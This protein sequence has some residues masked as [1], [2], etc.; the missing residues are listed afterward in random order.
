MAA[1]RWQFSAGYTLLWFKGGTYPPLATTGNVNDTFPGAIGQPGTVILDNGNRSPGASSAFRTTFTYWL[2][3]PEVFCFDANFF[4]MEQRSVLRNFASDANGLPLLARP[5]FNPIS[6]SEDADP[7]AVPFAAAGTL[8]D[9]VRTRLMGSELNL[10]WYS[11]NL[12][13]G[14][15]FC[16]FVGIRWLRLDERY[17]SY[18]TSN[19]LGGGGTNTTLSDTFSTINNFVGGQ[20]GGEWM[21]RWGRANFGIFSKIAY[22]PNYQTIQISG[23]TVQTDLTTGNVITD[24]QGLFA[25][26]SNVG[27]YTAISGSVLPEIGVKFNA[28]LSDRIRF[29]VGYTYFWMYNTVRPGDQIDRRVNIQPLLSGGGFGAPLPTPPSFQRSIFDTQML[30]FALEFTF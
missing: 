11:N 3:D 13:E 21:Y 18:D 28:D 5:Y 6:G 29:H 8:S 24:T 1:A 26:P 14:A 25:Q 4:I 7:R 9:S 2:M 12:S 16:F 22:G 30:N 27:N 10:K 23:K 19:D 15:N 20:V 17:S